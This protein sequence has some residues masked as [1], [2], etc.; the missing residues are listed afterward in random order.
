LK[1]NSWITFPPTLVN[2]IFGFI[3]DGKFLQVGGYFWGK[4]KNNDIPKK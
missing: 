1:L 3:F 2:N 4:V